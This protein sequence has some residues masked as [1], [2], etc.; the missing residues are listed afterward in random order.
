MTVWSCHL[1]TSQAVPLRGW[2]RGLQV[3][4]EK[5][6]VVVWVDVDSTAPLNWD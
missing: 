2:L 4:N 6:A 5:V 3:C 1:K